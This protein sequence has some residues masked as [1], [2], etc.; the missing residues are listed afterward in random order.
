M[1]NLLFIL[2]LFLTAAVLIGCAVGS[3]DEKHYIHRV[4]RTGGTDKKKCKANPSC[5]ALKLTGNCCP[6]NDGVT[7]DC[8]KFDSTKCRSNTGCDKLGLKGECCPTIDG[9]F[10]DCCKV[11]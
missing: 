7:L 3:V 8:C 5:A 2:T 11:K 1:N 9:K 6:T 4:L 10:L